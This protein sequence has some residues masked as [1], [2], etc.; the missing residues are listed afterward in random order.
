MLPAPVDFQL[1]RKAVAFVE[2]RKSGTFDGRNV[3][4]CVGLAVIAL[5]EAETL[6]RIKEFY[7]ALGLFARQLPLRAALGAFH[8]HRFA[9]DPEVG[10]RNTAPAVDQGELQRLSVGEIG[11]AGLLDG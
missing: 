3:N 1:E 10:G 11:E 4:E 2:S 5:N 7:R 6:H 8:R 9:F